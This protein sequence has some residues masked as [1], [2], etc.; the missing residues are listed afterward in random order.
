MPT[1]FYHIQ[2]AEELLQHPDL[3]FPLRKWLQ[4]QRP[5]FLFGNTAP[6]VQTISGQPRQATHFFDL[7]LRTN[8]PRPWERLLAE[9]PQLSEPLRLPPVQAAFLAGYLCH[10]LADW[11]WID[12]IFAPVFG[13]DSTWL[14]FGPRLFLHNV[15]RVY[16]DQQILAVI[17]NGTGSVLSWVVPHDW[18]PF[19]LDRHL[20]AW[21]DLLAAQLRPGAQIQTVE[22]FA[23]RQGIAPEHFYN[24]L[25]SEERLEEEIFSRLPRQN[26]EEYRLGL[27]SESASLLQAYLAGLT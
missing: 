17:P 23:T 10:L 25:A 16:L 21:R 24:L 1:P 19:V 26:L 14:S 6:D 22:V 8:D 2:V 13:P 3:P 27:I 11:L 5:A 7:P 15:L 18:L 9:Y 4:R 12:R 20:I